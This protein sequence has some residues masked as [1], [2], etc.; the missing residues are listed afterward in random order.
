MY[1]LLTI[2]R[3]KETTE[4]LITNISQF[5]INTS[6]MRDTSPSSTVEKPQA[7]TEPLRAVS[8]MRESPYHA[9]PF[10]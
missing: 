9:K 2:L 3:T 7:D 6:R 10:L 1:V 4:V 8:R 5:F